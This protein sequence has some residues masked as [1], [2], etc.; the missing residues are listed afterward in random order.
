MRQAVEALAIPHPGLVRPGFVTVSAGVAGA[1][2]GDSS[3]A[4]LLERADVALYEAK[5]GGRNRV[6]VTGRPE[7]ADRT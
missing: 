1:R 2:P 7:T 4:E 5:N 3:V 6:V